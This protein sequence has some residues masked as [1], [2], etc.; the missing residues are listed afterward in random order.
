MRNQSKQPKYQ[1]KIQEGVR[2][3]ESAVVT[4]REKTAKEKEHIKEAFMAHFLFRS[5]DAKMKSKVIDL[6]KHFRLQ[7]NEVV[8][9]QGLPG[10][11]F[12][13]VIGGTLRIEVNG[14]QKGKLQMGDHFGELAL[15]GEAERSCTIITKTQVELWGLDQFSF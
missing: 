9:N 14:I 4:V 8:F 5:L 13:I 15:I 6:M 11:H 3:A 10:I 2:E 12:F 7:Q 1:S